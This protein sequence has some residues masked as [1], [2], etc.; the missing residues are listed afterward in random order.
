MKGLHPL[1]TDIKGLEHLSV[2]HK[3]NSF[4]WL[5][6][7]S[8]FKTYYICIVTYVLYHVNNVSFQSNLKYISRAILMPKMFWSLHPE[9]WW[10]KSFEISIL[11]FLD[12]IVWNSKDV[13]KTTHCEHIIIRKLEFETNLPFHLS[14]YLILSFT[15]PELIQF[16]E[17]LSRLRN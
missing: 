11:D 16:Y 14:L 5:F 4:D 9:S 15:M 17:T 1:V 10:W 8:K 12:F 13:Y 3:L 7:F 6:C 2:L